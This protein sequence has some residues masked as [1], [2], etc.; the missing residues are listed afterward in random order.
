M[1]SWGEKGELKPRNLR[2]GGTFLVGSY[3][4][5][6]DQQSLNHKR[7]GPNCGCTSTLK[8]NNEK[9]TL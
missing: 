8:R 1:N 6:R 7:H 4:T 5:Q 9:T 3:L 2:K